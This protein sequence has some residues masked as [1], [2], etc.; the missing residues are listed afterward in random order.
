VKKTL[1]SWTLLLL[2]GLLYMHCT[3][4]S[5]QSPAKFN[6]SKADGC[7]SCHT[8]ADLLKSL[9]TPLPPVTESG[10]G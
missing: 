5:P 10:E 1:L 4:K 8:N 2:A 3:E 9:A 6:L 7:V